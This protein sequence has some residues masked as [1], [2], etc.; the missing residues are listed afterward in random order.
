[1]ARGLAAE[2]AEESDG[3]SEF[4]LGSRILISMT[5][6]ADSSALQPDVRGEMQERRLE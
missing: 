5:S 2:Q 1:M 4:W 6:T 3:A